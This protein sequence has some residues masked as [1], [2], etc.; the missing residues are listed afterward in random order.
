M[1]TAAND[2]Q[3]LNQAFMAGADDFPTKPIDEFVSWRVPPQPGWWV[4][5]EQERRALR[6]EELHPEHGPARGDVRVSFI[7]PVTGLLRERAR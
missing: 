7:Q 2:V 3:L 1:L 5:R 4:Q 6:E